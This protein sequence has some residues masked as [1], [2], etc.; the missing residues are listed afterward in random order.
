MQRKTSLIPKCCDPIYISEN[1]CLQLK[2]VK[3]QPNET[4]NVSVVTEV[5]GLMSC[6]LKTLQKYFAHVFNMFMNSA[7][8]IFFFSNSHIENIFAQ[9][10][11]NN[12]LGRQPDRS[13]PFN[14]EIRWSKS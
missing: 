1:L 4:P 10:H 8:V 14:D 11:R 13:T 2:F 7:T 5:S 9:Y 3:V 12:L 6:L